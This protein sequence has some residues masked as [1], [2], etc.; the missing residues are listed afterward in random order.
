MRR[1]LC[2]NNSVHRIP[3]A[4]WQEIRA[5]VVHPIVVV[6]WPAGGRMHI[7]RSNAVDAPSFF[8]RSRRHLGALGHASS[9][10]LRA[11]LLPLD[12]TQ[13]LKRCQAQRSSFFQ[14][15][16]RPRERQQSQD[17]NDACLRFSDVATIVM[18]RYFQNEPCSLARLHLL[19]ITLPK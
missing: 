4:L 7:A 2:L 18:F 13:L 9:Q 11:C 19:N 14:S 15:A 8:V 10:R 6:G 16:V 5:E 12:I 17:G 1:T 3:A